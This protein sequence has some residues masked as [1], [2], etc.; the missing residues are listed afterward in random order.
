M[1]LSFLVKVKTKFKL[2]LHLI[3]Y[4]Q[5][6]FNFFVYC[7]FNIDF[8][9]NVL[10]MV[11]CDKKVYIFYQKM[12]IAAS[13]YIQWYIKKP[14][15]KKKKK[16]FWKIVKPF[17]IAVLQFT[18]FIFLSFYLKIFKAIFFQTNLFNFD[19]NSKQPTKNKPTSLSTTTS[20]TIENK[21]MIYIRV[22]EGT[23]IC[24]QN[25]KIWDRSFDGD[26]NISH[27]SEAICKLFEIKRRE[28]FVNKPYPN[29]ISTF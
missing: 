2:A 19:L 27:N 17:C 10:V 8:L 13:L 16:R 1:F 6:F 3:L 20:F 28:C 12:L 22:P 24:N 7:A 26:I 29:L 25:G 11:F 14:Q 4:K 18:Y 9:N 15:K 5:E 23:Q 21:K